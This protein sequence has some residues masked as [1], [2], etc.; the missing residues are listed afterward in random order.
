[1]I[2]HAWLTQLSASE[3]PRCLRHRR[4]AAP[5]HMPPALR[6]GLPCDRACAAPANATRHR[7]TSSLAP[8]SGLATCPTRNR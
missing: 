4:Q 3:P 1:M 7:H 6:R 2:S 8:L 5:P